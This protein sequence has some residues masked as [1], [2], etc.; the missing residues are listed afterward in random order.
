MHDIIYFGDRYLYGYKFKKCRDFLRQFTLFCSLAVEGEHGKRDLFP[1]RTK[2]I[3]RFVNNKN[4][5]IFAILLKPH[6]WKQAQLNKKYK[7]L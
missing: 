2:I 5:P 4:L 6:R 1:L 3:H 7:A